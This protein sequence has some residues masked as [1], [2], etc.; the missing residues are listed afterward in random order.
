MN[1]R[2]G[3]KVDIDCKASRDREPDEK[4]DEAEVKAQHE[5]E[6]SGLFLAVHPDSFP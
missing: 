6:H 4:W 5:V 1:I 2:N 3:W